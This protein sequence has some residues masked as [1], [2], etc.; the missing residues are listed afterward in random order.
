MNKNDVL[1]SAK[2][3]SLDD[4]V[5][6]STPE[7]LW[8]LFGELL[9]HYYPIVINLGC[10]ASSEGFVVDSADDLKEFVHMLLHKDDD[11]NEED[12]NE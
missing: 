9:K 2:S 7:E 5:L 8:I 12:D 3:K 11:D 6:E 4:F 1:Q 10:Y